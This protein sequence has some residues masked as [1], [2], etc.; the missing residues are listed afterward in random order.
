MNTSTE[1]VHDL[2]AA[3]A[4]VPGLH[5]ATLAKARQTPWGSNWD[6]LA[7]DVTDETGGGHTVVV[8]VVATRLPL[9]PLVRRAEQALLAV[10][11]ASHVPV[12][13]LCLEITDLDNTAF[14]G[15]P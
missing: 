9:P 12:T 8:R 11:A 2:L 15:H 4:E 5:P 10:V 7:V 3:L 1:L 6:T 13:R 14:S